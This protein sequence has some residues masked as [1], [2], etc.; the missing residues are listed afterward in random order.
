MHFINAYQTEAVQTRKNEVAKTHNVFDVILAKLITGNLNLLIMVSCVFYTIVKCEIPQTPKRYKSVYLRY[1][2]KKSKEYIDDFST[3]LTPMTTQADDGSKTLETLI[4]TFKPLGVPVLLITPII[5]TLF[6]IVQLKFKAKNTYIL[7]SL[8]IG[9]IANVINCILWFLPED[10]VTEVNTKTVVA[11]LKQVI[12][13]AIVPELA[14]ETPLI[15]G[16]KVKRKL[17]EDVNLCSFEPTGEA[18]TM[19]FTQ[20][21]PNFEEPTEDEGEDECGLNFDEIKRNLEATEDCVSEFRTP[22]EQEEEEELPPC[23]APLLTVEF[24]NFPVHD[25]EGY[26]IVHC[27]GLD[28]TLGKGFAKFLDSK[29]K[30]KEEIQNQKRSLGDCVKVQRG[31]TTIYNLITKPKSGHVPL[32]SEH[33]WFDQAVIKLPNDEF[34]CPALG[35][36][37]DKR[38]PIEILTNLLNCEPAK[39]TIYMG[40][41]RKNSGLQEKIMSKFSENFACVGDDEV[42]YIDEDSEIAEANYQCHLDEEPE[43]TPMSSQ[44]LQNVLDSVL[45]RLITYVLISICGITVGHFWKFKFSSIVAIFK[46]ATDLRTGFTAV[47]EEILPFFGFTTPSS[48]R[49]VAV[50]EHFDKLTTYMEHPS[51][52]YMKDHILL[53]DFH[54]DYIAATKFSQSWPPVYRTEIEVLRGLLIACG[55]RYSSLK[56]SIDAIGIRPMPACYL[57]TGIEGI[58]KTKM[59]EALARD[60]SRKI[61]PGKKPGDCIAHI[62]NE[63]Y[64]PHLGQQNIHI[65]DDIGTDPTTVREKFLNEMKNIVNT[66]RF[67]AE[68]ADVE[69]KCQ[70]YEP[71]LILCTMN[72]TREEFVMY[73]S[74]MYG[75]SSIPAV[76]S[77]FRLLQAV[78]N[79]T[80]PAPDPRNRLSLVVDETGHFKHLDLTA[81]EYKKATNTLESTK[82]LIP[83]ETLKRNILKDIAEA[84]KQHAAAITEMQT[85]SATSVDHFVIHFSGDI[86]Q[87]KSYYINN[88]LLPRFANLT[89]L[90]IHHL[91]KEDLFGNTIY[92]KCICVVDDVL[93]VHEGKTIGEREFIEFFNRRLANGSIIIFSTNIKPLWSFRFR[94][95]IS[96]ISITIPFTDTR[97]DTPILVPKLQYNYPFE[98]PA[99]LRRA[100]FRIGVPQNWLDCN[101]PFIEVNNWKYKHAGKLVDGLQLAEN[102]WTSYNRW[103]IS[104]EEFSIVEG[105]YCVLTPNIKLEIR[106]DVPNTNSIL[107]L[108]SHVYPDVCD[109]ETADASWKV[110]LD[111]DLIPKCAPHFSRLA[112]SI[113]TRTHE[114]AIIQLK[115]FGTIFKEIGVE[116]RME[117]K[118]VGVGDYLLTA[119]KIQYQLVGEPQDKIEALV[120]SQRRVINFI[121]RK[122]IFNTQLTYEQVFNYMDSGLTFPFLHTLDM[123]QAQV[124]A[125]IFDSNFKN[126]FAQE[127]Q[128]YLKKKNDSLKEVWRVEQLAKI[129]T[130]FNSTKGKILLSVLATIMALSSIWLFVQFVKKTKSLFSSQAKHDPAEQL[131]KAL[132]KEGQKAGIYGDICH[133]RA[134]TCDYLYKNTFGQVVF[135]PECMRSEA[136]VLQQAP[137]WHHISMMPFWDITKPLTPQSVLVTDI[138]DFCALSDNVQVI[139]PRD[140]KEHVEDWEWEEIRAIPTSATHWVEPG[141]KINLPELVYG[142]IVCMGRKK[143]MYCDTEVPP[144][145]NTKLM[146][147]KGFVDKIIEQQIKNGMVSEKRRK[148]S[149]KKV[150]YTPSEEKPKEEVVLKVPKGQGQRRT[151]LNCENVM[152]LKP[153]NDYSCLTPLEAAKNKMH[154]NLGQIYMVPRNEEILVG[155]P[156]AQTCYGLAIKDHYIV[157]VKHAYIGAKNSGQNLYFSRDEERGKFYKL[158]FVSAFPDRDLCLMK[159]CSIKHPAFPDITSLMMR[160]SDMPQVFNVTLYRYG[161]NK[162]V[163]AHSATCDAHFE[164]YEMLLDETRQYFK[165][166]GWV[167]FGSLRSKITTDGDCGLP[168]IIG[169]GEQYAGRLAGIHFCGNSTAEHTATMAFGMLFLEDLE[170]AMAKTEPAL[171]EETAYLPGKP[172]GYDCEDCEIC[173]KD[174]KGVRKNTFRIPKADHGTCYVAWHNEHPIEIPKFKKFEHYN[175]CGTSLLQFIEENAITNAVLEVNCGPTSGGS[176]PHPHIQLLTNA[177]MFYPPQK[178]TKWTRY[179][180]D[181]FPE[182]ELGEV[183]APQVAIDGTLTLEELRIIGTRFCESIPSTEFKFVGQL[184][185]GLINYTIYTTA[186]YKEKK[187]VPQNSENLSTLIMPDGQAVLGYPNLVSFIGEINENLGKGVPYDVPISG[188]TKTTVIG[189]FVSDQSPLSKS[190]FHRTPFSKRLETPNEKAPFNPNTDEA[191]QEIKETFVLDNFGRLNPRA[192]QSVQFDHESPPLDE[193]LMKHVI[194]EFSEDVNQYYSDLRELNDKE[195][196]D[197]FSNLHEMKGGMNSLELDTSC[198]FSLKKLFRKTKKSDFMSKDDKGHVTFKDTVEGNFCQRSITTPSK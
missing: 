182:L 151:P 168:Y 68:S 57:I 61:N 39:F 154:K 43:F 194:R 51:D 157:T 16:V 93:L 79:P 55:K 32:T 66:A 85:E 4:E 153:M 33:K 10:A 69:H 116:P 13:A 169:S 54:A 113:T 181:K 74:Q 72:L 140:I 20:Q 131:L 71:L 36:G 12:T 109:Y 134:E 121:S 62:G 7:I 2:I 108:Q 125:K 186:G 86:H 158:E 30:I 75:K 22:E 139:L 141:K 137:E 41:E 119:N 44:S 162:H 178:R 170:E 97:Y 117:V 9:L 50:M 47:A 65:F 63:K 114:N 100:G 15:P 160:I 27:I 136:I 196:L 143:A 38:D 53:A 115:K 185:A 21:L 166:I 84:A 67:V 99:I 40:E 5:T 184:Y 48:K 25:C 150:K 17:A 26:N 133:P 179:E 11:E 198:G 64:W 60:I 173:K 31:S 148:N 190:R 123:T 76:F 146:V 187:L 70:N 89:R 104:R 91:S 45:G 14:E 118:L 188:K 176:Q 144:Y 128:D 145:T 120:D 1:R 142:K 191:P 23:P 161:K 98:N 28:A 46:S 18:A 107:E 105:P 122:A 163:E 90:P 81:I 6:A 24:C 82:D 126:Q 165:K 34:I 138:P 78:R 152:N 171:M 92:E 197:G 192:N 80:Y 49:Q 52:K 56:Q 87:G 189:S 177:Q 111:F 112:P 83:Y 183:Q 159:L 155:E 175:D 130:F 95:E 8:V 37:L 195:V 132:L 147:P 124:F 102:I 156:W 42:I 77:R 73:L 110:W 19:N 180:V 29:F 96:S 3:C 149:G 127:Y 103:L 167:V 164:T 94:F 106:D 174:M 35:M 193:K 59:V 172:N 101:S 135:I 88:T 58:G 129:T